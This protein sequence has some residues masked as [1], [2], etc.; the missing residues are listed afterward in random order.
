MN[1]NIFSHK[2]NKNKYSE[3]DRIKFKKPIYVRDDLETLNRLFKCNSKKKKKYN[4]SSKIS[5]GFRGLKGNAFKFSEKNQRVTF[6][7]SYSNSVKSHDQY[8]NYYMQQHNKDYVEE[9]P[10]L[11]GMNEQ[12]YEKH[13]VPLN[14]KCIIS[15]ESNDINLET[16]VGSFIK[17]V[18]NQTGYKLCWMGCIHNDTGHRH[19]HVV[20]NGRDLN[21][22]DV[23]FN[24]NTIQ[25]MRLMCSNAATQMIGERTEEQIKAAKKN[26]IKAKRWTPLDEKIIQAATQKDGFMVTSRLPM[27]LE[28]RLRYISSLQLADY[29][30]ENNCWKLAKNYRE[31][32]TASGRY[33]TYLEEYS[34]NPD[35]PLELYTG[36]GI[37]GKV[38]KVITFDKD[39]A[40][41]NALI[42][43]TGNK[44]VYVPVWQLHKDDLQG[45]NVTIKNTGGEA[46]LARQV[47]DKNIIVRD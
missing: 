34:K 21:G 33:N 2:P 37:K 29:D 17:R 14:F 27:E 6:K 1:K 31:V 45:K 32:L 36:G 20:I 38:E 42:I 47:S 35:E 46:K 24:K 26:L 41:N 44:R 5:G 28:N 30:K 40:W 18:E 13:K 15:P 7:M 43:N 12:E 19:A 9:K 11:F 39:E 25:L 10:M 8:I 16:L 4:P 23:F 22:N 3:N